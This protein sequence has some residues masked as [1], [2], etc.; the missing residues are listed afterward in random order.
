MDPRRNL[1][2]TL[3]QVGI[4]NGTF[5]IQTGEEAALLT[6]R[7]TTRARS[8]CGI[9]ANWRTLRYLTAFSLD[10]ATRFDGCKSLLKLLD[11]YQ[12]SEGATG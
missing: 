7:Q 12:R 5:A 9:I 6:E 3:V 4:S 10:K 2:P 11:R 8:G 1:K